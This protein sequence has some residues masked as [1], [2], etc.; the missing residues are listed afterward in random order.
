MVKHLNAEINK[1]CLGVTVVTILICI[2]SKGGGTK[3][4]GYVNS[5]M[6]LRYTS[7]NVSVIGYVK[8]WLDQM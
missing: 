7:S 6:N 5:E 3:V 1:N 8:S 4:C 2:L